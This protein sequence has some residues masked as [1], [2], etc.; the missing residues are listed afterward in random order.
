MSKKEISEQTIKI[1]QSKG[2]EY[3][4]EDRVRDDEINKRIK[5]C[6]YSG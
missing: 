4:Y 6:Q 1:K 3:T 2:K 5:F